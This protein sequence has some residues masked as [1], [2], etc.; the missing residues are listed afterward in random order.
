MPDRLIRWLA[1]LLPGRARDEM[2]LP[3]CQDL[4]VA[5]LRA[6]HLRAAPRGRPARGRPARGRAWA[7][8]VLAVAVLWVDCWRLAAVARLERWAPRSARLAVEA[9]RRR[10]SPAERSSMFLAQIRQALRSFVRQPLFAIAATLTLALGVGV[11]TAVFAVVEAV[12]LRPLPYPD[13][14]R[15]VVLRHR[16]APTGRTKPDIAIGDY[17]DL[18]ARQST[19]DRLAAWAG[20]RATFIEGGETVAAT[21]L[22]V[23][24]G[25][26]DLVGARAVQ[27]RLIEADDARDGA[28]P[29]V[30]LGHALWQ[31]TF[32]GDAGVIGR[33]LQLG[34]RDWQ[35]V[36]VAAPGLEFPLGQAP[37]L[38]VPM[39][40]PAAAPAQRRSRWVYA[41]GRMRPGV[42]VEAVTRDVEAVAVQLEQEMPAKNQG[43]RYYALTERDAIVGGTRTPLLLLAGA[44]GL[45]LLI[46]CAN[47]ANLLL[48]RG[49]GRRQEMALRVALGAGRGRMASQLVSESLVLSAAGSLAGLAAAWWTLPA[50]IALA[51]PSELAP[52][53]AQVSLDARV[54]LLAAGIT[55]ATTVLF[56]LISGLTVRAGAGAGASRVSATAAARRASST[57]VAAEIALAVVLLLGSGLI[58]RS[59]AKLMAI[60]PGFATDHV[61]TT[62]ITLP[63]PRYASDAALHDFYRRAFDALRG[64]PGV[65]AAG[66]AA[67]M[68]LT[69]NNWTTGFAR[70]DRPLPPGERPPEVGWQ[71]ASAGYFEALRIPLRDGRLF[72][73]QD[74]PGGAL[75]VIVSESIARQFFP[76]ERAVGRRVRLG[77]DDAEIVGVVG[78]IRRASLT[79][80]PRQD[81][82]LPFEQA[83]SGNAITLY[84]RT[85]GD[86]ELAAPA[87]RE[88]L[89]Q[90][91]PNVGLGAARSMARVRDASIAPTTFAMTLLGLF[92]AVALALAAIGVHA[93]TT[94]AVRQ[95]TREIGT[96]IALGATPD[97]VV[98]MIVRQGIVVAGAG[99]ATG[100]GLGLI[101]ARALTSLLHDVSTTDLPTMTGTVAVLAVVATTACYL[102]ARRAARLDAARTLTSPGS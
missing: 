48:A 5:H 32:A 60:D 86:P 51:P 53:L 11:N 70:A 23:G 62:A 69:G 61:L 81:L 43:S 10:P 80:V 57:L 88:A 19:M 4:R 100:L 73:P 31:S 24:P 58:L 74:T 102:P 28:A 30:V 44:V 49:V 63:S 34:S 37:D 21:V 89:K 95:R 36:G 54:I 39:P 79:D 6:A 78:D 8:L 15:L 40:M 50:L 82:Y 46:A 59:F 91:E 47:V 14:D 17:V 84:L 75:V 56:S 87:V 35:I 45:I 20:G 71:V 7:A 90:I 9:A 38:I 27:G 3:A 42:S 96:R 67:V 98:W 13:A 33:R 66:A 68:P 97:A 65:E 76:G 12:L 22:Q 16:D 29:V 55:A 83:P 52:L 94:Y 72:G 85:S 18:A 92:A 2:F 99:A 26:L 25:L 64:L 41:L 101:A 77:G 1:R 93:V